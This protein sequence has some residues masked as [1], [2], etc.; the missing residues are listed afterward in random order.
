MDEHLVEE[1]LSKYNIPKRRSVRPLIYALTFIAASVVWI[2]LSP[3]QI[4]PWWDCRI[5]EYARNMSARIHLLDSCLRDGDLSGLNKAVIHFKRG[6]AYS[7]TGLYGEALRD[8]DE[9]I[10]LHHNYAFAYY[11]RARIYMELRQYP[12]AIQDL[13]A[14]IRLEPRAS[15]ALHNR[16]LTHL[17]MGERSL[18]LRDFDAAIRHNPDNIDALFSRADVHVLNGNFKLAIEDLTQ[19]IRLNPD[20]AKY[21]LFRGRA[22]AIEKNFDN[23]IGDANKAIQ[24]SDA[25]RTAQDPADL[26]RFYDGF[27][28]SDEAYTSKVTE[29]SR[30]RIHALSKV[31]LVLAYA[32]KLESGNKEELKKVQTFLSSVGYYTDAI[33]GIFRTTIT[34]SLIQCIAAVNCDLKIDPVTGLQN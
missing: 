30:P 3:P 22:N 14:A 23:A 6:N 12:R 17:W 2:N 25:P 8:Y 11:N 1:Y 32:K 34:T 31:L 10:R 7:I 28:F 13:D 21:Y 18:A 9:A 16:G 4:A 27:N 5:G 15:L 29:R 19:T 26:R 20:N 33:D 24:L